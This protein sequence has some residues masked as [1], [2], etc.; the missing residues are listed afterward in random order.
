[1]P[2]FVVTHRAIVE[3]EDERGAARLAAGK[4]ADA[5]ELAFEVESEGSVQRIIVPAG[6]KTT[7]DGGRQPFDQVENSKVDI[8]GRATVEGGNAEE[9]DRT[10]LHAPRGRRWHSAGA[11]LALAFGLMC[12]ILSVVVRYG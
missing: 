11:G 8:T 9:A 3:A 12:L 7:Q 4:I 10:L 5:S 2:Y 6:G 1:V